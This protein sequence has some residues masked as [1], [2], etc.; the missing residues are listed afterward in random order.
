MSNTPEYESATE[1][2]FDYFLKELA[3]GQSPPDLSTRIATAWSREQAGLAT[4]AERGAERCAASLGVSTQPA[5]PQL[6]RARPLQA[7]QP[8]QTRTVSDDPTPTGEPIVA[9]RTQPRNG[10]SL[11]R[12]VIA[13][14]LALCACGLLALL[15]WRLVEQDR[16]LAQRLFALLPSPSQNASSNQAAAHP[17]TEP[18]EAMLAASGQPTDASESASPQ[19]A[20]MARA[21]EAIDGQTQSFPLDSGLATNS[22][23]P[24]TSA[25]STAK[26]GDSPRLDSQQIVAQIDRHL[27]NLWQGLSITPSKRLNH[28]ERAQRIS[29]VLTGQ[30]AINPDSDLG[31]WISEA[32]DSLPF[33]RKWAD[34]FVALW[35]ANSRLPKGDVR[36]QALKKH[37]ASNIYEGRPWSSAPGELLGGSIAGGSSGQDAVTSTFFSALA[38]DGNHRLVAAIGSSFLDVN[39]SCV[40]CHDAS[41]PAPAIEQ[42][43]SVRWPAQMAER[44]SS[45]W[46]LAA[47]LQGIDARTD[48][49]GTRVAVDRQAELLAAGKPLTAYYDLLDGRLQVAEPGLPDGQAWQS[50]SAANAVPRQALAEWLS[51]SPAADAAT[52]NQVWEMVFGHA[53]VSHA[54]W[55][56][57][58]SREA[59]VQAQRGEILQLL[60]QQYRAHGHDLKQLVGWIVLSDA[61]CRQTVQPTRAQW[62]AASAEQ[63]QQ[64]QLAQENFATGAKPISST[65]GSSLEKTLLTVLK[66]REQPENGSV[67]TTLAQPAPSPASSAN[68][69]RSSAGDANQTET[70]YQ[71]AERHQL[72]VPAASDIALVEHLLASQRLSWKNC[73][74]HVAGLAPYQLRDSR[75]QAL[76]DEL[77][78]QHNGDARAT[79]LD[80]VWAVRH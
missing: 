5:H 68:P 70:L 78:R 55:Q 7:Q 28:A 33:A 21:S 29:L 76:A 34:Q 58:S 54:P 6:V 71:L 30:P 51:Q 13:T 57:A 73:V 20:D 40:R 47:M 53:L 59:Q 14:L 67:E 52:V 27:A 45:Y 24:V 66:W 35:L 80:L 1:Q 36:L 60:A 42:P 15:S 23:I 79:L 75:F 74:E 22:S 64:W 65:V 39:L 46:S 43:T 50:M 49:E 17:Q 18:S 2:V 9:T 69:P 32:T 77:L 3:S 56:A 31:Q 63:L 48:A 62:L 25:E 72:D 38:G 37:F 4:P 12:N 26:V 8:V 19:P 61:L 44:Q 11:R 10:T 16:Q 41:S